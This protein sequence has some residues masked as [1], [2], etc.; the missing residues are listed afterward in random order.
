MLRVSGA[1]R[2]RDEGVEIVHLRSKVLF[3]LF[4]LFA[5]GAR[6]GGREL[7]ACHLLVELFGEVC[8][9]GEALDSS[10]LLGNG[11]DA[12]EGVLDDTE[13]CDAI[14]ECR[15]ALREEDL[16][17]VP[18]LSGLRRNAGR[19]RR[20]RVELRR[21]SNSFAAAAIACSSMWSPITDRRPPTAGIVHA[22]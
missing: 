13:C 2:S 20:I 16:T 11:V 8:V 17:T 18:F 7:R 14:A 21:V 6:I 15:T 10:Q 19:S 9:G 12:V 22:G 5:G 1:Q 4:E 3:D